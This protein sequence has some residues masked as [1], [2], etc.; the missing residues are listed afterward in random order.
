MILNFS[1]KERVLLQTKDIQS[2]C[3]CINQLYKGLGGWILQMLELKKF[4]RFSTGGPLLTL[5]LRLWKNNR[6]SR[7][8]YTRRSDLVLN[9]QMRVPN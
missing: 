7:K 3:P 5:F 9:G 1:V 6:V 2:S 4:K 8:P